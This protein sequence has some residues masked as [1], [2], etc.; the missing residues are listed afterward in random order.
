MIAT[1]VASS[2]HRSNPSTMPSE[3]T[4]LKRK[5]T[6]IASEIRVIMPG[7]RLRS[8][9]YPPL[10]HGQPPEKYTIVPNTAG[11]YADPVNGRSEER[12]V[13]T[14]RMAAAMAE[15]ADDNRH[16]RADPE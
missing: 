16:A 5:A 13:A 4:A 7:R 11:M 6:V 2:H 15:S 3:T 14:E 12:R 9:W 10:R 8:S 1:N